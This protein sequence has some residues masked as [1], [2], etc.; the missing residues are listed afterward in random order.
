MG[1]ALARRRIFEVMGAV[2]LHP[3]YA[4]QWAPVDYL[5]F[6]A[7]LVVVAALLAYFLPVEVEARLA[8]RRNRQKP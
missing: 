5:M 6:A 3:C 8:K 4:L 7:V 1:W 2:S